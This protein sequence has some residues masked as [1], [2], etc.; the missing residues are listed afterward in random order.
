MKE[1]EKK[2]AQL[3]NELKERTQL[4]DDTLELK[5]EEAAK[6]AAALAAKQK[7]CDQQI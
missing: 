4:V 6:F 7:E 2:L 5:A 3:E 1:T